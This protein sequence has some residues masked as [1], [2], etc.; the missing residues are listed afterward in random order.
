MPSKNFTDPVIANLLTEVDSSYDYLWC[1]D[2]GNKD[3]NKEITE[4]EH[5][6]DDCN[7]EK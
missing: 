7:K 3:E 4:S 1:D 2:E 6:D 5:E